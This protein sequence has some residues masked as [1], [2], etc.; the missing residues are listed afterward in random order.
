MKEPV[1]ER[2]P[3]WYPDPDDPA[4]LLHWDGRNWGVERRPRP[5]WASPARPPE[6]AQRRARR[7]RWALYA[8]GGAALAALASFGLSSLTSGLDL[9]PRTVF[10]RAFIRQ[11]DAECTRVL[12]S[13]RERRPEPGV[14]NATTVDETL[15]RVEQATEDLEGL[16]ARLRSLSVASVDQRDIDGWLDDWDRY[17]A[18]GRRYATLLRSGDDEREAADVANTGRPVETEIAAF[19]VANAMRACAF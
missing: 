13:L 7:R 3:G 6:R 1:Q 8:G 2:A 19:A 16:V 5:A 4:W 12:P 18:I 11:A 17:I 15:E 9:P 14:E 10:D